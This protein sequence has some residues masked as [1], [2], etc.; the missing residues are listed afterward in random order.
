MSAVDGEIKSM[1]VLASYRRLG[2][3]SRILAHIEH[4]ARTAGLTRLWLETGAQPAF[5]P[6]RRFYAT[7]G[8]APCG[9]FA[10]Y[11]SSPHS[12]FMTKQL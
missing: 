11:A 10:G 5:A 6:A 9:P 8:Y 7:S 1:H 4:E 12:A 2:L 3:A